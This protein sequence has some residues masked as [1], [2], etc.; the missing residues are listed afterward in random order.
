M[1]KFQQRVYDRLVKIDAALKESERRKEEKKVLDRE[2]NI[3]SPIVHWGGAFI[4]LCVG[5]VWIGAWGFGLTSFLFLT[6]I[7]VY[8]IYRPIAKR[9]KKEEEFANAKRQVELWQEAQRVRW[10]A[11]SPEEQEEELFEDRINDAVD[12]A[13]KDALRTHKYRR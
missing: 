4:Y 5:T 7:V 6:L 8:L 12:S 13:V 10:N 3:H 2:R 11:L 1:N 9:R